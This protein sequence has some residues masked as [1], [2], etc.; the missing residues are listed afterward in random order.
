MI[1]NEH[2]T[3]LPIRIYTL[4]AMGYPKQPSDEFIPMPP[5]KQQSPVMAIQKFSVPPPVLPVEPKNVP[6]DFAWVILTKN[7][8]ILYLHAW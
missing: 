4:G 8:T 7:Y 6:P 5:Q 2:K 3:I 1:S